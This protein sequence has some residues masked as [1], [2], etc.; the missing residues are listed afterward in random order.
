[1]T[2]QLELQHGALEE[3]DAVAV[4]V[5]KR[6]AAEKNL[7]SA[8]QVRCHET[9]LEELQGRLERDNEPPLSKDPPPSFVSTPEKSAKSPE[10]VC[11]FN[12]AQAWIFRS[13]DPLAGRRCTRLTRRW[14]N[15]L[16]RL[17]HPRPHLQSTTSRPKL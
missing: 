9:A 5:E 8:F 7:E 1:M 13:S 11:A 15:T 12:L 3:N 10:K 16:T 4:E 14:K 6:K 17:Q 2:A